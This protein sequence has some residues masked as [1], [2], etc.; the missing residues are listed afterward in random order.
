MYDVSL[1][2]E[3]FIYFEVMIEGLYH[4]FPITLAYLFTFY[5]FSYQLTPT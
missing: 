2:T 5:I 4:P 1:K 3:N